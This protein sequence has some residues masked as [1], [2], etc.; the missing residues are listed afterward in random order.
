MHFYKKR[1][2]IYLVVPRYTP[3]KFVIFYHLLRN[4]DTWIL[5][6]SSFCLRL[7]PDCPLLV[8]HQLIPVPNEKKRNKT[9][10]LYCHYITLSCSW[11]I[12]EV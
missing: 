9:L 8:L 5:S 2:Y 6:L 11:S 12:N 1:L 4:R 10:H 7:F 3:W